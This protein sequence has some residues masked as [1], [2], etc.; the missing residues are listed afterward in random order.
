MLLLIPTWAALFVGCFAIGALAYRLLFRVFRGALDGFQIFWLGLAAAVAYLE[1][2]SLAFPVDARAFVPLGALALAGAP[3]GARLLA[4][5]L[6]RAFRDRA[7]FVCGLAGALVIA[8]AAA[9]AA[10]LAITW[11]DSRLAH[12]QQVQW[13]HAYGAVPGLANLNPKLGFD[14]AAHVL[15][16]LTD[17]STLPGGAGHVALGFLTAVVLV[18][19]LCVA[20]GRGPRAP[21][22]YCA[23]TGAF[24][25]GKV[26]TSYQLSSFS[27]DLPMVLAALVT[28]LELARLPPRRNELRA[29]LV[30]TLAALTLAFKLS[31]SVLALTAGGFA[32]R[33][34]WRRGRRARLAA[35]ILPSLLV[36]GLI[37]R[38]VVLSGW[39]LYPIPIANLHLPWSVPAEVTREHYL[40]VRYWARMHTDYRDVM[41]RPFGYWFVPWLAE[42]RR[43]CEW[44]LL[45]ASGALAALGAITAVRRRSMAERAALVGGA[46]SIPY[47]LYAAPD[48]RFGDVFFW[49]VFALVAAPLLAPAADRPLGRLALL[50]GW[51][52]LANWTHGFDLPAP[53]R[54]SWLALE[55]PPGVPPT[56]LVTAQNGQEPPL[57]IRVPEDEFCDGA[58]PPCSDRARNPRWRVPGALGRGFLPAL[59]AAAQTLPALD[60]KPASNCAID[61]TYD[62]ALD[63]HAPPGA[64]RSGWTLV[65]RGEH[66]EKYG[67]L[68]G[69]AAL[70]FVSCGD[71]DRVI[72]VRAWTLDAAPTLLQ[73]ELNGHSLPRFP[74]RATPTDRSLIVPRAW[75]VRGSNQL[76]F[77]AVPAVAADGARPSRVAVESI[78][79]RTGL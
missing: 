22:L 49:I 5:E 8:L 17:Y 37:A 36:L 31:A 66:G 34:V 14:S 1:L 24:L 68:D 27:S 35:L 71:G 11:C 52:A 6:R 29:A 4:R 15:A 20:L 48:L 38:R 60:P 74:V 43:T 3:F 50:A 56:R 10:S 55:H 12:I 21:R 25:L 19:W 75:L 58:P 9:D 39:P 77:E 73:L 63:E 65:A 59:D 72:W 69:E 33:V 18:E 44:W 28:T 41:A 54:G 32:L 53:S 70:R 67:A 61:E 16:A 45:I 47:W 26:A 23:I 30:L 13:T 51:L 40:L 79:L 7:R 78:R 2:H 64:L 42:F 62:L 46:L 57:V 76:L